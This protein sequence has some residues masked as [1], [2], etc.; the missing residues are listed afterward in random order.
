MMRKLLP[1]CVV[2]EM[3]LSQQ[4]ACCSFVQPKLCFLCLH[5]FHP[6]LVQSH[7]HP[8]PVLLNVPFCLFPQAQ[9]C[10]WLQSRYNTTGLGE[11]GSTWNVLWMCGW[12]SLGAPGGTLSAQGV[13]LG[14][15]WVC[16]VTARVCGWLITSYSALMQIDKSLFRD[17]FGFLACF[18]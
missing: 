16:G 7:P 18:T 2:W 12:S 5:R 15:C 17:K 11:G 14:S 10:C 13:A 3:F 4:D 6:G 8:L 1:S 9:R